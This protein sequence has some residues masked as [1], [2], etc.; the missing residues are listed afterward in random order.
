MATDIPGIDS[1]KDSVS[2]LD[3]E[4][5]KFAKNENN[6]VVVRV[7]DEAAISRLSGGLLAGISYDA[8]S[9]AYPNNQTEVYT[10][11]LQAVTVATVTLVYTNNSKN[12]LS[13]FQ[14]VT[15]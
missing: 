12:E 5:R 11:T 6:K 2:T 15:P 4:R 7:E 14:V 10:F 9:V 1:T 13:T 8:G 3:N